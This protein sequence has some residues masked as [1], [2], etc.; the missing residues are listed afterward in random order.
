MGAG[1]G[2]Y[3]VKKS[4]WGKGGGGGGLIANQ[5]PLPRT[6]KGR[7]FP[8]SNERNSKRGGVSLEGGGT[9]RRGGKKNEDRKEIIK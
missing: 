2:C 8:K 3:E 4:Q 5:H 1:G 6:S 7:Q 9:Y